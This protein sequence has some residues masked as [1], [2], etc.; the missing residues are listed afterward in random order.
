MRASVEVADGGECLPPFGEP[1][2]DL[3]EF[4]FEALDRLAQVFQPR[5]LGDRLARQFAVLGAGGLDRGVGSTQ[6]L[7][8]RA[9]GGGGLFGG[10]ATVGKGAVG[11]VPAGFGQLQFG[12]QRIEPVALAQPRRRGRGT[13]GGDGKAVPAPQAALAGDQPLAGGQ[14]GGKASGGRVVGG[15]ADLGEPAG[16]P[17][18]AGDVAIQRFGAGGQRGGVGRGRQ[19]LPVARGD[20]VVGGDEVVA[21]CRAE[22][23]LEA[24]RNVQPV[25]DRRP[26]DVVG[27]LGEHRL[28]RL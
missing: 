10:V 16:Q 28:E 15:D 17:R 24:W 4:A 3:G 1:A 25:E 21:E 20:I 9:F 13:A 22:R 2:V 14:G 11:G 5:G 8:R 26:R 23:G 18:R 12:A 27:H 19:R 7:A 6:C